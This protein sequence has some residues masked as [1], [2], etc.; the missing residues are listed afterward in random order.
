MVEQVPIEARAAEYERERP[1]REHARSAHAR[2]RHFRVPHG[3]SRLGARGAAASNSRAG[4]TPPTP[5]AQAIAVARRPRRSKPRTIAACN[6][7]PIIGTS[8]EG[9]GPSCSSDA[10]RWRN[11]ERDAG[12]EQPA[13]H[14]TAVEHLEVASFRVIGLTELAV[15]RKVNRAIRTYVREHN[16]ADDG[17]GHAIVGMPI[18]C[19]VEVRALVQ[20]MTEAVNRD[21][22]GH[23]RQRRDQN[24][25]S[26]G[27][28]LETSRDHRD[29]RNRRCSR[30]KVRPNTDPPRVQAGSELAIRQAGRRN[31]VGPQRTEHAR[32][33]LEPY[34]ARRGR[35]VVFT[36]HGTHSPTLILYGE[37]IRPCAASVQPCGSRAPSIL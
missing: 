12:A 30:A 15:M 35:A 16:N 7:A 22:D 8:F 28:S 5:T 14:E 25:A 9:A 36:L 2:R 24:R 4:S 1:L 17:V 21:A 10:N 32:V 19:D 13:E 18:R 27:A 23:S 6:P 3:R 34:N 11:A 33:I 37:P 31:E 20:E 26:A 29:E